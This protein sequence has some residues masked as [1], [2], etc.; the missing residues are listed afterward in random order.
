[1]KVESF[2]QR[3]RCPLQV[4]K[5]QLVSQ[6][7]QQEKRSVG[8]G[9]NT[10]LLSKLQE[11]LK[12]VEGRLKAQTSEQ[13]KREQAM[14]LIRRDSTRCKELEQNLANVRGT[15]PTT[16]PTTAPKTEIGTE[17]QQQQQQQH[18]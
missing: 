16:A 1:M 15:E 2:V 8:D 13:K 17:L 10:T 3:F 6:L 9:P 7:S 11:Q 4:E 5:Q 12:S 18:H 14:D